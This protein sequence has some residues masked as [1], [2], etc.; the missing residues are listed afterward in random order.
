MLG[1][2]TTGSAVPCAGD[3]FEFYSVIVPVI[4][5]VAAAVIVIALLIRRKNKDK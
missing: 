2:C 1:S 5:V 4:L 3:T